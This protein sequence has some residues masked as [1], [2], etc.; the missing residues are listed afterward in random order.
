MINVSNRTEWMRQSAES[1]ACVLRAVQSVAPVRD[2]FSAQQLVGVPS[3]GLYSVAVDAAFL[4]QHG[5]LWKTGP[6]TSVLV[7]VCHRHVTTDRALA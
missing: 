1:G 5:R 7:K 3:A 2:F 4:D 6:R